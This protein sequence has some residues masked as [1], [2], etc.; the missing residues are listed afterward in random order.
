MSLTS[1]LTATFATTA[2]RFVSN[3][4]IFYEL[5]PTFLFLVLKKNIY[6]FLAVLGLRCC[7]W[8]FSNCGKQ[9]LL[10]VVVHG[11]LTVVA[12]LVEEHGLGVQASVV[13]AFRLQ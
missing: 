8:A 12:F 4:L 5:R 6:L 1:C 11:L 13:V 3:A 10:F 2:P 9:G 7:A